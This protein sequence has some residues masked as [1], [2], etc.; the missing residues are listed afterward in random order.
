M[1]IQKLQQKLQVQRGRQLA[2]IEC[3]QPELREYAKA[4]AD[5][6]QDISN[7]ATEKLFRRAILEFE[8][9]KSSYSNNPALFNYCTGKHRDPHARSMLNKGKELREM[10]KI[11]KKLRRELDIITAEKSAVPKE[12]G[13]IHKS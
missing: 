8:R 9:K 5:S 1:N 13:F 10:E 7:P 12:N 4:I 2:K 6:I 3:S 11:C